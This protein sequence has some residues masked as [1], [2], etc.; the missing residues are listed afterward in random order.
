MFIGNFD[1]VEPFKKD[2]LC[3]II[4]IILINTSL[5]ASVNNLS[6]H[7][8]NNLL[9]FSVDLRAKIPSFHFLIQTP[10]NANSLC[11][12]KFLRFVNLPLPV[13]QP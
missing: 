11:L 7:N 5:K 1:R 2:H 6:L 4:Q 12:K 8:L 10:L 3:G 13:G 9:L